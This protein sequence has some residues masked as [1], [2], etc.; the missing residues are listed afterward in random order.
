[1]LL[2]NRYRLKK[3]AHDTL[4]KFH[5]SELEAARVKSELLQMEFDQKKRELEAARKLQLSMLPEIIPVHPEFEI[6]ASMQ[7]ASEV[8]G[9]YYDFYEGRDGQLTIAIGDATGHGA[10]ASMLVAAT[11]SLFNLLSRED[12]IA[13]ILNK[14]NCSI[15]KMHMSNL[16]MAMGIVRLSG[17]KMELAGAGMPPALVYR[18]QTRM[19][20]SIALKGL[21]LGSSGD[22]PYSKCSIKFNK[23]DIVALMSDG[24]PELF[25]NEYEMLGYDKAALVLEKYSDRTPE[26]IIEQ[27]KASASNWLN[28]VK[29]QDDMTFIFIQ[30]SSFSE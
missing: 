7:T 14:M 19:I 12:D 27:F 4:Q 5:N 13:E 28:G 26:G 23:G 6:A 10:R 30:D 17:D 11:K 20:E 2:Y 18:E 1:L 22:F 21:P 3:Q 15:R 29:Q 8:G 9:D 16:F 24:Y 25:N